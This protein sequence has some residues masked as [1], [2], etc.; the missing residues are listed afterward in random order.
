MHL[1][2]QAIEAIKE[3]ICCYSS[4]EHKIVQ[5]KPYSI[6]ISPTA[7]RS[8]MGD[9]KLIVPKYILLEVTCA[10]GTTT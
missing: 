3:L 6:T 1:I 2:H 10:Y 8:L 4:S 9:D 7:N 5:L